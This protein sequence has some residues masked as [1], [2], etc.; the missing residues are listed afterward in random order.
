MLTNT[1]CEM[2]MVWHWW[3]NYPPIITKTVPPDILSNPAPYSRRLK[4]ILIPTSIFSLGSC[5]SEY[6]PCHGS[7]LG[8]RV[9]GSA[10]HLCKIPRDRVMVRSAALGNECSGSLKIGLEKHGLLISCLKQ[11]C[12]KGSLQSFKWPSVTIF[13]KAQISNVIWANIS[14]FVEV[15]PA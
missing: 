13:L 4:G 14:S 2:N 10:S 1:P 9:S 3:F 6:E 8:L 7:W 11:W 15:L 12:A 5:D